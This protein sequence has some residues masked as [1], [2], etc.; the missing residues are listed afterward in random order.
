MDLHMPEMDGLQ[1]ASEIQQMFA[2]G[3]GPRIV[4]MTA[5]VLKRDRDACHEAGMQDFLAKPINLDH[6]YRILS[7]VNTGSEQ[8]IPV[9]SVDGSVDI[10]FERL[11]MVRDTPNEDEGN[12]LAWVI[13]SFIAD[14]EERL[15]GMRDAVE[16]SD[17]DRL[18]EEA[19]RFYSSSSNLGLVKISNICIEMELEAANPEVNKIKLLDQ[20]DEAYAR[21][22]PELERQ[23][24]SPV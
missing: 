5:N 21:V 17:W 8:D 14:S 6:L 16:N 9:N 2:A 12:L 22:L 10:D 18:A 1:A 3:R 15:P 23:K 24:S 11:Q 4:A 20:L 13:D 19:H 7:N